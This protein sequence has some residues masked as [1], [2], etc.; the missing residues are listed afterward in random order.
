M[1]GLLNI[2]S[3]NQVFIII[4]FI[5]LLVWI[6]FLSDRKPKR[7]VLFFGDSITQQG[8]GPNGYISILEGMLQDE[9]IK[10]FSLS[11]S[12]IGG[13]TVDDLLSRVGKDV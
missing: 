4:F 13:N 7:K 2:F 12:G 11:E 9:S 5:A 1:S 10:T 8:A 3:I 6:S